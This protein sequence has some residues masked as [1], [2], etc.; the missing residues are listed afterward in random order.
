MKKQAP[1]NQQNSTSQLPINFSVKSITNQ[2][3]SAKIVS[4]NR[5]SDRLRNSLLNQIIENTKS[6]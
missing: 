2:T 3:D 1:K 5:P 4:I 6:F